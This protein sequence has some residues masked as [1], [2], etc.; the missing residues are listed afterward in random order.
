MKTNTHFVSYLAYFFLEWEIL[1]TNVVE[2][3][4]THILCSITFSRESC[5]LWDVVK[6]F[7]TG[8][9]TD[10]TIRRIRIAC[11]VT[12]ATHTHS[13]W[14]IIITFQQQQW[15]RERA[16]MSRYSRLPVLSQSIKKPLIHVYRL[17]IALRVSN[18]MT[19]WNIVTILGRLNIMNIYYC[20]RLTRT[21]VTLTE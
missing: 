1:H 4:K 6:Y 17:A 15:L 19:V 7:T 16:S 20:P 9:A 18:T 12:K 2:K 13:E 8:H 10:N 14:V 3:I 21:A 5:R 11:W